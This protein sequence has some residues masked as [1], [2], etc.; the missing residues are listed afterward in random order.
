MANMDRLSISRVPNQN[1][2]SLLFIMLEIHHSG[3]EL[4]ICSSCLTQMCINWQAAQIKKCLISNQV[5]N[6]KHVSIVH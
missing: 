6:Q 5:H 3:Q 4:S 2:V 1:G